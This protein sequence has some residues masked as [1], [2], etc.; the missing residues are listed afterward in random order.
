MYTLPHDLADMLPILKH[1]WCRTCLIKWLKTSQSWKNADFYSVS[2]HCWDFPNLE[3]L[4]QILRQITL[5]SFSPSCNLAEAYLALSQCWAIPN[6][7][8]CQHIPCHITM[9]SCSPPYIFAD[10]YPVFLYCCVIPNLKTLFLFTLSYHMAEN[11]PILKRCWFVACLF[12]LLR[13]SQC[14]NNVDITLSDYIDASFPS[15]NTAEAYLLLLSCWAIHSLQTLLI[16]TLSFYLAE[17][18]PI[19]K[20]CWGI[21]CLITLLTCCQS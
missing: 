6:L 18:L 4:P 10:A 2:L 7:K 11:F 5:L 9:L 16:S 12:T 14:W 20:H 17:L 8:T 15:C 19:L 3:K 13:C 1:S 21:P